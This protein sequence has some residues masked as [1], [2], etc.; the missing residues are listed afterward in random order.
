MMSEE[1]IKEWF[2]DKYESETPPEEWD[3]LDICEVVCKY[4][5][6]NSIKAHI[7]LSDLIENNII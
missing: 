3:V 5:I 2:F 6:N 7:V 1:E 4:E